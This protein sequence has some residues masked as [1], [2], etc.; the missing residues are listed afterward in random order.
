MAVGYGSRRIMP[1]AYN[2]KSVKDV[3]ILNDEHFAHKGQFLLL[4]DKAIPKNSKVYMEITVTKQSI[5]KDIRHIPIYVGIHKEPSFGILASDFCL[6]NVFYTKSQYLNTYSSKDYYL[7]FHVMDRYATQLNI[8]NQFF[9]TVTSK[10]PILN[11]VIGIGVDMVTGYINIFTDGQLFYSFKPVQFDITNQP[12]DIF[13]AMYMAEATEYIEGDFNLGRCGVKYLPAGYL[14]LYDEYFYKK[15]VNV[16]ITSKVQVNAMYGNS[17]N[18]TILNGKLN[19]NNT[20]APIGPNGRR[21]VILI[22]NTPNMDFYTDA[23]KTKLNPRAYEF[24]NSPAALAFPER[25]WICYPIP[26]NQKV[27]FE[28]SS[29]DGEFVSTNYEGIPVRVGLTTDLNNIMQNTYLVDLFHEIR[30]PYNIHMYSTGNYYQYANSYISSP[31]FPVQPNTI[32]MLIDLQNNKFTLYNDDVVFASFPCIKA[33]NDFTKEGMANLTWV[34]FEV[35]SSFLVTGDVGHVI[36][37]FGEEQFKYQRLVDNVSVMSI[38]Y[39]YNHTIKYPIMHEFLCTIKV[40]PEKININKFISCLITVGD[41]N[42]SV[43]TPGLNKMWGTYNKVGNYNDS[44]KPHN[45]TPTISPFLLNRVME[46]DKNTNRR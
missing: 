14:S 16:D 42:E 38:D 37:N 5:E 7:A 3:S 4:S 6:G 17:L 30:L 26:V 36:C 28:F 10:V 45:N 44:L 22:K 32:G 9:K 24:H 33:L 18:S 20:I 35:P 29:R 13:F 12:N 23:A 8:E 31:N 2:D 19:L 34:L 39:Y 46:A 15:A 25:A 27:Y 21:D 11:T 41:P 43:W 40:V 1:V